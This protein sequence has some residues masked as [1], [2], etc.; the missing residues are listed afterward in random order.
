MDYA[1]DPYYFYLCE[2]CVCG[3]LRQQKQARAASAGDFPPAGRSSLDMFERFA[4]R[5][6][7][8]AQDVVGAWA[9]VSPQAPLGS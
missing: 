7:A 5:F 2:H 8:S 6:S 3:K 1:A 4:E 9:Q